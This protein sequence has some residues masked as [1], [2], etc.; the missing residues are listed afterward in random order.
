MDREILNKMISGPEKNHYVGLYS[1]SQKFNTL[2]QML[3]KCGV[4]H[5]LAICIEEMSEL[6]KELT[7]VLRGNPSRLGIMEEMVDVQMSLDYISVIFDTRF[8]P[9]ISAI[10]NIKLD[11]MKRY[12][13]DQNS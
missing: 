4:E 12:L 11:R 10:H 9:K 8:D 2:N 3:L 6:Q 1:E 5:I 7:K 13:E